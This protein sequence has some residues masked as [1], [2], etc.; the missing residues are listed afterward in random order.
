MNKLD[1]STP[2][3]TTIVFKRHFAAK[4]ET[5]FAAFT[6]ADL[7]LQWYGSEPYPVTHAKSDAWPGGTYR[8][9][10]TGP[11]G[12]VTAVTGHYN[13]VEP[14]HRI[15]SREIFDE[16]WTGGETLSTTLFEAT[17]GGTLMTMTVAYS[18]AEAR[19]NVLA[20]PMAEGLE[21]SFANLEALLAKQSA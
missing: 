17:E 11:D 18:S 15:V 14:P 16:D 8:L 1:V 5:V 2:N 20:T 9:E 21:R 19:D 3:Q 7:M 4:P 10:W 6:K 12:H 13:T